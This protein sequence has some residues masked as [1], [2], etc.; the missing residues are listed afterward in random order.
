MSI[1]VAWL[2]T[3]FP[4]LKNLATLSSGGQKWVFSADH[5]TDGAVVLKVFKPSGTPSGI[6]LVFREMIAVQ[7]VASPRIPVILDQGEIDTHLGKCFWFREQRIEGSDLGDVIQ[8]GALDTRRL[9]RLGLHALEALSKA[10]EVSIVHRDVKPANI[11][12]D[13]SDDFWLLDFGL[14]RHLTLASM[15]PTADVFGKC[16]P[17]Y[18]PPEQFR[19]VKT[20]IDGRADLFGLGVTLYECATGDNPF[21]QGARTMLDVLHNVE[22]KPLVP[23]RLS[24][25]SANEFR[26]LVSAMTQK[27]RDHR[28][29][30]VAEALDWMRDICSRENI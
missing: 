27:R 12:L 22:T 24:F 13:S 19:N 3:K 18:A 11:M 20:E 10:E 15:T 6:E 21:R 2:R 26:D 9:L 16:T 30:T 4:D 7:T 14:A 28:L 8:S 17:G 5:G 1:D 29:P 23:L 25:G